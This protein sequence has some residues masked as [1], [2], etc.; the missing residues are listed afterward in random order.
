MDR[1]VYEG[2]VDR[3][4][5]QAL[6]SPAAFRSKVV[7]IS[8]AAYV[9]L[10]VALAAIAVAIYAGIQWAYAG[11][12][13]SLI[14]IALFAVTMVPVFFAVL[15]M[16]FMRLP[17]P[18]GRR[19]GREE[20]PKLFEVLDKMRRKLKGPPIHHV[21]I[22]DAYNAAIAQIPRWGMFGGHTSYLI[23][24][25]PYLLGVP[26][27]EMLATVAHEYGHLC[28]NH[29]KL[30][31]WVY[32]QRRTFGALYEQVDASREDNWV[33]GLLAMA[34][35]RFMPYYNAYTFVLSRQ[36]EYEADLT[37]TDLVGAEANASG[38]IRDALLGRWIHEQ[39]W[40]TI[41]KQAN[42]I[43][44]PAI[45]PFA[46]MRTAFKASYEQWATRER[47]MQAWREQSGL[48]DTHPSL[49]DRVEA[50]G[51]EAELPAPLEVTAAEA[52][53][54]A[55]TARR[56]I[57]EFDQTWWKAEQKEWEARYRYV[58]RSQKRLSELAQHQLDALALHDLQEL[59][60]LKAEFESPLAAK[61]A[62][63]HLLKKPGGPFPKASYY[64][65]RILLGEDDDRGLEYLATAARADRSLTERAAEAGYYYERD[66]RGEEA[67]RVWWESVVPQEEAA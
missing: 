4:E 44:R 51:H 58:Q 20:A 6:N 3:L 63:E 14:T 57:V 10:F 38:L 40:S 23:L 52:L 46:S 50:T 25:L 22:D 30:S 34:L 39:F 28:G 11:K 35:D 45:M 16:F 12:R 17:P 8:A 59:A 41:F 49:R 21:L 42:T 24:G 66:K 2:L 37:A 7:L 19:I 48:H 64:Y 65:G 31:S 61:P 15:R 53:L 47:L 32:R 27:K 55:A 5:A 56:L 29:G 62:L 60:L 13:A 18:Q 67:A 33:H 43:P 1:Y 54:G 9:A 36:N 26:P